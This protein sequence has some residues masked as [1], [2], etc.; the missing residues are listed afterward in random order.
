MGA[1][2]PG[3]LGKLP[4]KVLSGNSKDEEEVA[5]QG[6]RESELGVGAWNSSD[7]AAGT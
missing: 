5:R 4:L 6:I 3:A 2:N 1:P 7:K